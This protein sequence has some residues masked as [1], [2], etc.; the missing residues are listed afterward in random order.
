[1]MKQRFLQHIGTILESR[2]KLTKEKSSVESHFVIGQ[3][4]ARS[5]SARSNKK[6]R[7]SLKNQGNRHR[8]KNIAGHIAPRTSV[9]AEW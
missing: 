9:H 8:P 3:G 2:E 6:L 4:N 1:M 7:D 5:F